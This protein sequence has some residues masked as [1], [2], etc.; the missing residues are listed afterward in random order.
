MTA[1]DSALVGAQ[2]APANSAA[3][4]KKKIE[5]PGRRDAHSRDNTHRLLQ[6]RPVAPSSAAHITP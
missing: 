4:R 3:H 5:K 6:P 1:Y 2:N